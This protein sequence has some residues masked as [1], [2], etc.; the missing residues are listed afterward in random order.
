MRRCELFE[1]TR[2]Q[3]GCALFSLFLFVAL[4]SL[5]L[6]FPSPFRPVLFKSRTLLMGN[7]IYGK[8]FNILSLASRVQNSKR[9]P[10]RCPTSATKEMNAVVRQF[11]SWP[12]RILN[13]QTNLAHPNS[14][15]S[16]L[17]ETPPDSPAH[18]ARE[19][20][21]REAT[22]TIGVEPVPTLLLPPRPPSPAEA[23]TTTPATA[24]TMAA[25]ASQSRMASQ[26]VDSCGNLLDPGLVA[27]AEVSSSIGLVFLSES[28]EGVGTR[29]GGRLGGAAAQ[30]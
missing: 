4:L 21:V 13:L 23:P 9:G 17:P 18:E 3:A 12:S 19:E 29:S 6:F 24:A 14:P 27:F 7:P 22:E 15:I 20:I 10:Q 25:A 28:P 2:R 16:H 30:R 11:C 8:S 1:R 26:R 5:S